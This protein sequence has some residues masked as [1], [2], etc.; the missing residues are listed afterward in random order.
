[1]KAEESPRR[2][3]LLSQSGEKGEGLVGDARALGPSKLPEVQPLTL[4]A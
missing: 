2:K 1:M 4:P 3:R